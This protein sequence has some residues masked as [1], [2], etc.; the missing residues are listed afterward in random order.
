[1]R[2]KLAALVGGIVL[3]GAG[4]FGMTA[5]A[6]ETSG[7]FFA[8]QNAY[9]GQLRVV[10]SPAFCTGT[11]VLWEIEGEVFVPPPP[12]ATPEPMATSID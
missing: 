11:N 9:T 10:H 3:L 6:V 7:T 8:C 12:T 4:L 1:M 2:K 5:T